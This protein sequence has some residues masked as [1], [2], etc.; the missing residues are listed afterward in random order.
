MTESGASTA[1]R[2]MAGMSCEAMSGGTT[3][4]FVS[5]AGV[6]AGAPGGGTKPGAAQPGWSIEALCAS[7]K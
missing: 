7:P 1:T 5:A 6:H 4:S 3:G 2:S